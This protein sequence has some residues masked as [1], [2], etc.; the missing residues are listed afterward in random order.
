MAEILV[1][2]TSEKILLWMHRNNITGQEIAKK[3]AK[4]VLE[5]LSEKPKKKDGE[6]NA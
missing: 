3:V 4:K 1:H 6:D 2:K 5:N